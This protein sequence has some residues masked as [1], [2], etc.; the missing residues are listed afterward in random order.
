MAQTYLQLVNKVLIAL[1]EDE[2]R[3]F[4]EP[5]AKMIAQFVN[6]AK[7]EVEDKGPWQALRT[8]ITFASAASATTSTLTST[9]ERSYVLRDGDGRAM[10][11]RTDSGSEQQ[12]QV[13]P[14]ETLRAL[15]LSSDST[16]AEPQ[17]VA[18]VSNGTDLVA[19]FYP[20]PDAIYNYK[21]VFVVPQAE[22]SDKDDLLT[23]NYRPVVQLATFYAMDERGSEFSGRLE[24]T[25][26]KY[27]MQLAEY[28]LADFGTEIR[29]M[30]EE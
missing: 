16:T 14:I 9:N 21:G 4:T 15:R 13:I 29:T 10:V 20:L 30:Q 25:R 6:E 2:V 12:I 28:Q 8:E 22:L 3:G 1:R 23:I 27:T 7:A 5:Y 18:F 24:T 17:Y 11:F 26:E 19:H